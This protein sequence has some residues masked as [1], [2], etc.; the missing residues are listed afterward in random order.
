MQMQMGDFNTISIMGLGLGNQTVQ[1]VAAALA[2][3]FL[4]IVSN[5]VGS[6]SWVVVT[7]D[8]C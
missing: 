2:D 4:T 1:V 6:S 3:I 8:H 5:V 7:F